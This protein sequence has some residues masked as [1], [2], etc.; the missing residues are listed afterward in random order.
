MPAIVAGR[1]CDGC[2][3]CC[4]LPAVHSLGKPANSWCRHADGG[5]RCAI[6]GAHPAECRAFHCGW[7]TLEFLGEEW[8]PARARIVLVGENDGGRITALVDPARPDAWRMAPYHA[9]LRAWAAAAVPH[10]GQVVVRVGRRYW[11]VLPDRDVALGEVGTDEVIV[12]ATT[13]GPD[14]TVVD[15]MK[16][17]RSD[18]RTTGM[19]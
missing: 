6:H 12:T 10:E 5:R 2:A 18:P 14:G 17:P 7:L 8:I 19:T 1:S 3:M 4:L 13:R 9:Q 16:L 11:V 15:A